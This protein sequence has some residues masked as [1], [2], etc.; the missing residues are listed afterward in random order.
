[1]GKPN[2]SRGNTVLDLRLY[3]SDCNKT[4]QSG[5]KT[6]WNRAEDP[7]INPHSYGYLIPDKVIKNTQREEDRPLS[8]G[9]GKTA[10]YLQ[11]KEV[12]VTSLTLQSQHKMGQMPSLKL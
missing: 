6:T 12:R 2:I 4:A 10:P 8:H 7:E 11:N 1:M 9:T 3:S 5:Y